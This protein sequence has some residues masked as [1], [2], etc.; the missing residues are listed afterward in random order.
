MERV[1]L[2]DDTLA[3]L[4]HLDRYLQVCDETGRVLGYIT[5]AVNQ[6]LESPLGDAELQRRIEE[7]ERLTTEEVLEHWE[8]L[9]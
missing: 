6:P 1:V 7:P 9:G 3:Q 2:P 8:N 5:P 4:H